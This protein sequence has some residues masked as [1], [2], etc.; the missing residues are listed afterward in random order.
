MVGPK[1][2]NAKFPWDAAYNPN[3]VTPEDVETVGYCIEA[4]VHLSNFY[5]NDMD[6]RVKY[7]SPELGIPELFTVLI[8]RPPVDL[9]PNLKKKM[10]DLRTRLAPDAEDAEYAEKIAAE[11]E[12]AAVES[13]HNASLNAPQHLMISYSQEYKKELIIDLELS[14]RDLGYEVYRNEVGSA[15]V[16]P[17]NASNI[18]KR[19]PEAVDNAH[20]VIVCVS[21]AYKDDINCLAEAKYIMGRL[22]VSELKV[23]NTSST[24]MS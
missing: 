7:M 16:G 22:H 1:A 3:A 8:D 23:C 19:M 11:G 2:S 21:P 9:G 13:V 18:S 10:I 20:T 15:I 4:M 12:R 24:Y 6:L 5:R 17:I 14:L